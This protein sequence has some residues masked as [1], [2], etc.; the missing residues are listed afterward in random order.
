[1]DAKLTRD[2]LFFVIIYAKCEH[3][4]LKKNMN[5]VSNAATFLAKNFNLSWIIQLTLKI[6][7]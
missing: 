3:V 4:V 5:L 2:T 6:I 7:W 1:M